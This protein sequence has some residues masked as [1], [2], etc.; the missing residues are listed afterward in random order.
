MIF[1]EQEHAGM[2]NYEMLSMFSEGSSPGMTAF[3]MWFMIKQENK[4]EAREKDLRNRYDS[5]K[6]EYREEAKLLQKQ[7]QELIKQGKD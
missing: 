4:Y 2:A 6:I 7:V 1:V 3:L 5:V